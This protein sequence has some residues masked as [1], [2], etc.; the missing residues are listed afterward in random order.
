MPQKFKNFVALWLIV[1]I[2]SPV[3]IKLGHHH[4][5]IYYQKTTEQ[6]IRCYHEKCAVCSFEFSVFVPRKCPVLFKKYELADRYA[7]F[8]LVSVFLIF[9]QF[10]FLLRAPPEFTNTLDLLL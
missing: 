3:V 9:S 5:H 10:S 6:Q 4:K 2:L 7:G 8:D 1:I